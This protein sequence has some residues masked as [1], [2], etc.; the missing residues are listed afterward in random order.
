MRKTNILFAALL[1][2]IS[3]CSAHLQAEEIALQD[4][5]A[6]QPLDNSKG[7][8]EDT[9]IDNHIVARFEGNA[10]KVDFKKPAGNVQAIIS[11][12]NGMLIHNQNC[13]NPTLL[14]F[15][16]QSAPAGCYTLE[17]HTIAGSV[18]GTFEVK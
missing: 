9:D 2:T 11:D 7:T 13:Q 17:V 6:V 12:S 3:L 8:W 18:G 5:Y 14:R 16:M 15:D 4:L 10:V 1:M